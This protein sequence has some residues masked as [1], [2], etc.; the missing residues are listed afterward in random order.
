MVFEEFLSKIGKR[1]FYSFFLGLLYVF[2]SYGTALLLFPQNV[3]ITMLFLITLLL[4]PSAITLISAEEA[5][6]SKHGLKKFFKDH[7]EVIEILFFLFKGVLVGYIILGFTVANYGDIF[8][9]Q[10]NFLESQGI[11][12]EL[13]TEFLESGQPQVRNFL[14]I[15]TNNISV[16]LIAFVLSFFYGIGA[17]FLIVLN[18]SI[19]TALVVLVVQQLGRTAQEVALLLGSFSIYIIPEV[20]GFLLAAIAGGVI[21]KAIIKEKIGSERFRNV[22]KDATILLIGSLLIILLAAFLEV[23]VTAPI[24]KALF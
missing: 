1:R 15:L 3:S 17:M 13:V 9:Y 12:K 19:F 2:I 18:A 14:G 22:V 7:V 20:V 24:I 8:N 21:S 11:S 4:V 10:N 6:E 5:K 23:F 16:S